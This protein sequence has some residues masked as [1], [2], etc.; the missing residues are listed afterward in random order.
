MVH[1]L[2]LT[3][4]KVPDENLTPQQR[5]HREEQLATL[6][7]M[8]QMLFPEHQSPMPEG[9]NVSQP[10]DVM[11]QHGMGPMMGMGPGGGP[12]GTMPQ[13]GLMMG[14]LGGP[15]QITPTSVAAQIEWQKLQQ[16]Y[17]EERK[18]KGPSG[19]VM[20]GSG[21]GIGSPAG[22]SMG[23]GPNGP[24]SCGPRAIGPGSAGTATGPGS[25]GS[26]PRAQGPP[27]PYHQTTRS[28]SVPN[29]MP[30]PNPASPSNQTSNLSLPSPRAASGLNSPA[31]PNRQQF[32]IGGNGNGNSGSS[33]RLVGSGPSPTGTHNTSLES[34][35]ASRPLNL[36][37]PSTPVSTHL[38]PSAARKDSSTE[39]PSLTP[40]S[41]Q[42]NTTSSNQ[43]PAG[44]SECFIYKRPRGKEST[45]AQTNTKYG[46]GK[47]K[48]L[49]KIEEN[50]GG[51]AH[52]NTG[53]PI[54]FYFDN[55]RCF[56][57]FVCAV[58]PEIS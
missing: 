5:Q 56:R 16:Q 22:P 43:Q 21:S 37:N 12:G 17:F 57:V 42:P 13:K 47:G 7:K 48:L 27:P 10:S 53:K 51:K 34:P 18:K 41:T 30:S 25:A 49:P 40:S 19:L 35:T 36:S 45:K 6:R 14:G 2:Y 9:G 44:K 32:P 54:V 31:D 52:A 15:N 55:H 3:G 39:F 1:C 29:A 58:S 38:S 28:A 20:G 46:K 8:Q 23:M 4:V 11:M 24:G 26:G 50:S 33:S